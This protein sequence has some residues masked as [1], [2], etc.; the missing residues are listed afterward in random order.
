MRSEESIYVNNDQA[1]IDLENL[2]S[3]IHTELVKNNIASTYKL[4]NSV[5][6]FSLIDTIISLFYVFFNP[7]YLLPSLISTIGYIGAFT[8]NNIVLYLLCYVVPI[9]CPF[10]NN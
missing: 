9:L 4:S 6:V 1:E 3:T 2:E 7:W 5:K 10:K 8:Y